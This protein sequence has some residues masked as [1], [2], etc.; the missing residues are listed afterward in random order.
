MGEGFPGCLGLGSFKDSPNAQRIPKSVCLIPIV[1][2]YRA[3]KWPMAQSVGYAENPKKLDCNFCC[4]KY[5]SYYSLA[6]LSCN[7]HHIPAAQSLCIYK[8]SSF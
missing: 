6:T 7:N 2:C 5:A 1:R 3:E 4:F 8:Y